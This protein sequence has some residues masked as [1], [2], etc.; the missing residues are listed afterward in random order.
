MF[1]ERLCFREFFFC[2]PLLFSLDLGGEKLKRLVIFLTVLFIVHSPA[3]L[4]AQNQIAPAGDG[5]EIIVSPDSESPVSNEDQFIIGNNDPETNGNQQPAGGSGVFLILRMLLVLVLAAAAIY[6]LVYF[7]KKLS[8]PRKAQ[9]P[10]LK[11]LSSVSLGPNRSVHVISVGERA[12]LVGS[13]DNA[14]S[15]ISEIDD[16]E[17]VDAMLLDS[18]RTSAEG[19]MGKFIDFKTMFSRLSGNQEEKSLPKSGSIKERRERFKG[20]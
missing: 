11:V 17:T 10:Y 4:F 16:K 14:V 2:V 12:W 8:Q 3:A 18:S 9:D 6:G 19:G 13:A 15:L 7:V 5:Q 20:F 1:R